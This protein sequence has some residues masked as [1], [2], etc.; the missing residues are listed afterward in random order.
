MQT[1][2]RERVS[3]HSENML[4]MVGINGST[5]MQGIPMLEMF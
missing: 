4:D 3:R 1:V 5:G 2:L